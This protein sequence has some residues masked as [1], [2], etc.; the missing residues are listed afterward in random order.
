M[1]RRGVEMTPPAR[2]RPTL[3]LHGVSAERSQ[4]RGKKAFTAVINDLTF[5]AE[6]GEAVGFLGSRR[7]GAALIAEV[8]TGNSV[9]TDGKIYV[10]GEPV[11]LD[12]AGSYDAEESLRFNMVRFATANRMSGQRV[13]SAVATV[14]AEAQ[15]GDETLDELVQNIDQEVVDRIRFYLALVTGTRILVIDEA[16][17][18]VELLA[19]DG[20]QRKLEAFHRR[21]GTLIVVSHEIRHL[22][23]LTNRI[24]WI[25]DGRVIMDD[26]PATV[27]RWRTQL[28]TAERKGE[29]KR[30]VQLLRRFQKGYIPPVLSVR[31]GA[32]RRVS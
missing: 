22:L 24:C 9:P 6:A 18:L 14:A 20:E 31:G 25:H 17:T 32:R 3:L 16:E 30:A 2:V 15:I 21:G 12:A 19:N 8:I 29:S 13:T 23:Q 5:L 4:G 11:V 10:D 7:D 26:E 1:Q 27:K 28:T